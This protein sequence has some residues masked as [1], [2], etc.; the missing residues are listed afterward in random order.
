MRRLTYIF[1]M[2][3]V[4]ALVTA[5]SAHKNTARS[6]FWQSFT[7]K[8]NTYYNGSQAFIEGNLEK[9]KGNKDNYTELLPLYAVGN[10][11]SRTLGSGNYDRA[12]EKMEKTI[13]LHSIKA[14]P[15]WKKNRRKTD[16]DREWL[17]R[18]EYNP[19]L[20]KAW[21][22]LG[23]AQFQKGDFDEAAA[24]FTYVSRIY[25]TQPMQNS[26]ARAWLAKCYTELRWIY[27]A[28]DVIRNMSR[29][30]IHYRSMRDW[31][32]AYANYYLCNGDY[33]KALPYLQKV[34]KHEHRKTQKARVWFIMGQIEASLGHQEAAYKAYGHTIRL[35]PPYELSFNARIA[36]T[37]VMASSRARQMISKLKRMAANDN[38][39][40]YLDQV[41]YAI[42]NIYLAQR[43]TM[44]AIG[45]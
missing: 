13:K 15:E 10:K 31:D 38:N 26:M 36:Q 29:D 30:S 1:Y 12:I 20:W 14:R 8:Y 16:K 43:D 45:A 28:E 3:A 32:A 6:R 23:K 42:G 41:Y 40:D 34:V 24:T 21:M 2:V 7:A 25:Q 17:S 5:C 9:E 37:E 19:F 35:N 27:E 22:M 44:K 11:Q 18:K 33:E 4:I 39:K